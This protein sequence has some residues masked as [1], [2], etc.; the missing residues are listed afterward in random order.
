VIYFLR[1]VEY[2]GAIG[3]V[4]VPSGTFDWWTQQ[5]KRTVGR[6]F[7]RAGLF[8]PRKWLKTEVVF[9]LTSIVGDATVRLEFDH[10]CLHLTCD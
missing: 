6:E 4:G 10:N 9:Y 8:P 1:G 2:R 7:Q 5:V 3:L